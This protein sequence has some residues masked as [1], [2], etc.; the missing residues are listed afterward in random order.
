MRHPPAAGRLAE[1]RLELSRLFE[2][3]LGRA[4]E[5]GALRADFAVSDLA[6]VLW[7]F[8]P[9]IDATAVAAPT[10]WRRHLHWLLDGL[11]AEAA[12][13]QAEPPLDDEQLREAMDCLREQRLHRK[14]GPPRRSEGA[15]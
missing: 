13:P 5:Q 15:R 10:A 12:T 8:A 14:P 1:T 2:Q 7:S 6:L 9:V 3:V 4:H 11:R